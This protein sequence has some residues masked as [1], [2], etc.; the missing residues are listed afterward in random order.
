MSE[1]FAS[2]RGFGDEVKIF[3]VTLDGAMHGAACK[4]AMETKFETK[5]AITQVI[6]PICLHM[7]ASFRGRA[8]ESDKFY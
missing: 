4:D 8:I 5:Q 1:I 2:N 3:C 7:V 6:S